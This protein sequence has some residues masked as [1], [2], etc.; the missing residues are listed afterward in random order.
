[1]LLLCTCIYHWR[2]VTG[3]KDCF[4]FFAVCL[5]DFK[6]ARLF[7]P[8]KTCLIESSSA[9]LFSF[10]STQRCALFLNSTLVHLPV[11]II[12]VFL[13]SQR[14]LL[15][16]IYLLIEV[17]HWPFYLLFLIAQI[18]HNLSFVIFSLLFNRQKSLNNQ[19]LFFLI[20]IFYWIFIVIRTN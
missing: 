18:P 4:I 20:W 17:L 9:R 13:I 15:W 19:Y 8:G 5:A 1:M 11:V 12:S 2:L 10:Q 7:C 16:L 3:K 6:E 14:H